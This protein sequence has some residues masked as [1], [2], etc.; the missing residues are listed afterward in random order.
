MRSLGTGVPVLGLCLSLAP[1][2]AAGDLVLIPDT[3]ADKVWAFSPYDGALVSNNWFPSDGR[4]KQVMQV[5]QLPGGTVV[6]TDTG[7]S[8]ACSADDS[9][10][11]YTPCGQYIRTIAS[12]ADGV[13]NP[14]GICVAYGKVW[15]TRLY[16]SASEPTPGQNA[17]WSFDFDGTGLMQACPSPDLQKI[18]GLLPFNGGFIVSDS[19]D[20]NLEFVPAGCTSAPPFFQS[21]VSS[22]LQF[23]QQVSAMPDGGVVA[24]GFSSPRGLHF[25]APDGSYQYTASFASGARGAFVL[26]NGEILYTGGTEVRAYNPQSDTHRVIVS[27]IGAS[28]RWISKITVCPE[29]LNCSGAIDGADLGQLLGNWGGSGAT[30]LD[31][32]GSTDGADLGMLLSQWGPCAG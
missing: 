18:W 30:D 8:Q 31:G 6:M 21:S 22:S 11:E 19:V 2:S 1:V 13:C 23:V 7:T 4:M 28:F 5:A 10:R 12:Q 26:G 9:V 24:A 20:N 3:G 15:F 27:Q 16:D 32:S 25:F 14:Q 29:D 17:L